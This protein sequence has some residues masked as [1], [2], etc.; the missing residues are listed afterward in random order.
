MK[1]APKTLLILVALLC[2]AGLLKATLPQT[3]IGTWTSTVG[4]SEG[5][6]NA[7]AVILSD[8]RILITGGN[9][10]SGPL[11]S[12][13]FF[14]TDGTVSSA[15]AMNVPRSGHFAVILGTAGYWSEA[16]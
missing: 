1:R 10:A 2:C 16:A 3:S 7:S 12:G 11:Q 13:E 5:R 14:G 4:F 15:A 6:S 8:G 9:G